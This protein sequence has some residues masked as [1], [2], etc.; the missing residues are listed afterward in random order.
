MAAEQTERFKEI[1]VT[2]EEVDH[3]SDGMG[4]KLAERY[5]GLNVLYVEMLNGGRPFAAKLMFA[6]AKHD[7]D[8]R[9]D[10]QSMKVTAYGESKEAGDPVLEQ[11]LSEEYRDLS[12]YDRVV[13][14]DDLIDT[15]VTLEYTKDHLA[16]YGAKEVEIV[17][18]ARKRKDVQRAIAEQAHIGIELDDVWLTGMGMDNGPLAKNAYRWYGGIAIPRD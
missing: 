2:P 11:D 16:A 3:I 1:L 18:L 8:A 6:I 4:A 15:G 9:L 17:V 14:I 12:A 13:I 5:K 10:L 7:V